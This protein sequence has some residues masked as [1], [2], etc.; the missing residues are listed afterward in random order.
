M[1]RVPGAW[2]DQLD[3]LDDPEIR[4]GRRIQRLSLGPES[5]RQLYDV[6]A[7]VMRNDSL[8]IRCWEAGGF[9]ATVLGADSLGWTITVPPKWKDRLLEMLAFETGSGIPYLDRGQ[10]LLHL[11]AERFERSDRAGVEIEDWLGSNHVPYERS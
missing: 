2:V 8:V 9:A 3:D 5:D 11:I 10:L 6:D 7:L 4:F 1:R